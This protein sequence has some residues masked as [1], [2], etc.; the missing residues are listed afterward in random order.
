MKS[1]ITEMQEKAVEN[2]E[3]AT[4]NMLIDLNKLIVRKY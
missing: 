2:I 1:N 3:T 4:Q